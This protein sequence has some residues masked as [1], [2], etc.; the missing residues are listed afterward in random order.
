MSIDIHPD[1]LKIIQKILNKY[2]SEDVKVWVFGSRAKQ[3]TKRSSDLDL[4]L[5]GREKINYQIII[6]LQCDFEES[7]L[8]YKVDLVDM[9]T[10]SRGFRKNIEKDKTLLRRHS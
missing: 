3:A 9:A 10:I 2:L 4:A 1:Q 5:E 8:P 7:D 6:Q